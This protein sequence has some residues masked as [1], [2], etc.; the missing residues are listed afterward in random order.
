MYRYLKRVAGV[1]GGNYIYFWKFKGLFDERSNSII[2]SKYSITPEL[3]YFGTKTRV[4]L[5]G[6]CLRQ[7]K[8]TYNRGTIVNIYIVYEASKNLNK[9]SSNTRKLFI[10]NS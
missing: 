4:E 5:N 6:S 10:W 3:S 1:D 2:A 8:I 7:D 9:Q